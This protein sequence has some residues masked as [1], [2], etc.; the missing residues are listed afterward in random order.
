MMRIWPMLQE[1]HRLLL[2]SALVAG[3]SDAG[4]SVLDGPDGKIGMS[5]VG[6]F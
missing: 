4:S 1:P 3:S 2:E 6:T 5:R